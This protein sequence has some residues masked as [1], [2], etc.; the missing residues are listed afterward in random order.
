MLAIGGDRGADAVPALA[1]AAAG[2][3]PV[4]MIGLT[5]FG[6]PL[7]WLAVGV[8]VPSVA[9]TAAVQHVSGRGAPATRLAVR[10]LVAGVIATFV[11]DLLRWAFV[12]SGTVGPDPIPHI[13]TALGV[14][15]AWLAGYL[16]RYVGNGG[17]LALAFLALGGRGP[18]QGVTFGLAVAAGLI[19]VLVVS[20]HGQDSLFAL[21][22]VSVVMIVA[23]H[24]V[25]GAVLGRL[26]TP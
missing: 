21:T 5:A 22:P 16:W 3:A 17:G 11:Y 2:A 18:R 20:P 4:T 9:A 14:E 6:L 10:A 7:T 8:L 26:T 25:Y 23:G 13:G 12:L 1:L 19:A 24:A 15:P